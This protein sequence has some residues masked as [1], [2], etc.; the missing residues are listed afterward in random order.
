MSYKVN[1]LTVLNSL[2]SIESLSLEMV[3][4]KCKY[5][6]LVASILLTFLNINALTLSFIS[7]RFY[8]LMLCV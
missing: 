5:L 7:I 6:T 2:T 8:V 4:I 3:Y 1:S